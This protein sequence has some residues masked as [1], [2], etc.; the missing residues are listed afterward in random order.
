[1][2][3]HFI[4]KKSQCRSH[5]PASQSQRG[6]GTC[7][8]NL[9]GIQ[10]FGDWAGELK[11]GNPHL[12]PRIS[13]VDYCDW[14]GQLREVEN[15]ACQWSVFLL[16]YVCSFILC[17]LSAVAFAFCFTFSR[18]DSPKQLCSHKHQG[19][20][21]FFPMFPHWSLDSWHFYYYPQKLLIS[22][23]GL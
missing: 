16:D 22:S 5:S 10:K 15:L 11:P 21:N 18:S 2:C 8:L 13:R 3:R 4:K 6:H 20:E 23:G 9:N 17:L 7:G 14:P 1:M 12:W 19:F